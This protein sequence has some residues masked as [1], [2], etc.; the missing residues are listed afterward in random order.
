MVNIFYAANKY[1][2]ACTKLNA[3]NR[4]VNFT[5]IVRLNLVNSIFTNTEKP[6]VYNSIINTYLTNK[7][8]GLI[9]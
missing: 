7:Y 5:F 1:M 3:F 2:H 6:V 4:A 8:S 9:K